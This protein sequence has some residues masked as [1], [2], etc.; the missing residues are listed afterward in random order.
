MAVPQKG[1]AY[2][3]TDEYLAL[4]D[5]SQCKHEYLDCVIYAIRGA[6]RR[7]AAWPAGAAYSGMSVSFGGSPT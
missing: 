7:C 1:A 3:E 4:E 6:E 5:A 2:I